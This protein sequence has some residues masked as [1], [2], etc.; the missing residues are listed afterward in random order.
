MR[1]TAVGILRV[2][3]IARAGQAKADQG[4]K[5]IDVIDKLHRPWGTF[6]RIGASPAAEKIDHDALRVAGINKK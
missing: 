4:T 1:P 6:L 3:H 5:A 2:V